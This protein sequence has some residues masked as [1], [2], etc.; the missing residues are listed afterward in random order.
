MCIAFVSG[1]GSQDM[2]RKSSSLTSRASQPACMLRQREHCRG[3]LNTLCDS[4]HAPCCCCWLL[5]YRDFTF[6]PV[7]YPAAELAEY[8]NRC[9]LWPH[10]PV[11]C[12]CACPAPFTPAAHHAHALMICAC[13]RHHLLPHMQPVSSNGRCA[14]NVS[15]GS[16][17]RCC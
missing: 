7:G 9:V 11:C 5:R 12:W 17:S 8:V 2:T 14:V 10:S 3:V 15:A 1:S 4:D 6:N 13:K 16:S